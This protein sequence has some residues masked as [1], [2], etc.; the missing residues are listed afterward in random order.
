MIELHCT[1]LD[2]AKAVNSLIYDDRFHDCRWGFV[3]GIVTSQVQQQLRQIS[4]SVR[5]RQEMLQLL[6]ESFFVSLTTRSRL[7]THSPPPVQGA[8]CSFVDIPFPFSFGVSSIEESTSMKLGR[9]GGSEGFDRKEPSEEPLPAK[10]SLDQTS[11]S[12]G[13]G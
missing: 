9:A 8:P 5:N 3:G 7:E 10:P 2:A 6:V 13:G 4:R 11:S 12:S 1:M